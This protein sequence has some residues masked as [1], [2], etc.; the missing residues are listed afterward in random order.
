MVGEDYLSN[1]VSH[2]ELEKIKSMSGT[3]GAFDHRMFR[4]SVSPVPR[5]RG[6]LAP[7]SVDLAPLEGIGT[8]RTDEESFFRAPFVHAALDLLKKCPLPEGV[9][10]PKFHETV[11]SVRYARHVDYMLEKEHQVLGVLGWY[12]E[13]SGM[14]TTE[15]GR[16]I[17][18]PPI[19]IYSA[20]FK[21]SHWARAIFNLG[22]LNEAGLE[23]ELRVRILGVARFIAR[24]RTHDPGEKKWVMLHADVKN[25]Y[26]GIPV[27]KKLSECC[28]IRVGKKI[29]KAK[30]LCMGWTNSC[31]ICQALTWGTILR[32]KKGAEDLG[33]PEWL[34]E[35]KEVPDIVEFSDGGWA[36][37][38]IDSI[39]MMLPE[40]RAELWKVRLEENFEHVRWK[41]KYLTRELESAVVT[42]GGVKIFAEPGK[43]SWGL[44]TETLSAWQAVARAEL[45][46]TP[47]AFF[48]PLGFLRFAGSI[49]GWPSYRLGRLTKYQ[50]D[51]GKVEQW[52]DEY[53]PIEALAEAKRLIL[54]I[55]PD[56]RSDRN[57]HVRK[58]RRGEVMFLA[59]DATPTR[60]AVY[61]LSDSEKMP[62]QDDIRCGVFKKKMLIDDAECFALSKAVLWG[63]AEDAAVSVIANDNQVVGYSYKKGFAKGRKDGEKAEV[64]DELI[65][66]L[67]LTDAGMVI[68]IGDVPGILNVSDIGTRPG[69]VYSE[70]NKMLRLRATWEVLRQAWENYKET[71]ATYM[72][73]NQL[74]GMEIWLER[75]DHDDDNGVVMNEPEMVETEEPPYDEEYE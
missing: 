48:R 29:L 17:P 23:V 59:V 61:R 45:R 37:V 8:L 22:V 66:K 7:P 72:L 32:R 42:F 47:R 56:T 10:L 1:F 3:I 31:A 60:W 35:A 38:I 44:D 54:E 24:L 26:Y 15:D 11:D 63:Y 25:A 67:E 69:K 18:L 74:S 12:D 30:V 68:V 46:P 71:A 39:F 51:L 40:E 14:V 16:R 75:A 28:C 57:S 20:V 13:K 64:M 6:A 33:V 52:D 36:V 62:A 2:K 43:L 70:E 41:L 73:R 65:K 9:V 50:S 19:G 34:Y 55:D 21:D 49:L 53:V 58:R 5:A 4:K 27:G